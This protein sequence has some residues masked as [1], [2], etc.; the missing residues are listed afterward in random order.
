MGAQ[1]PNRPQ[2][3][4]NLSRA[5]S[6]QQVIGA[7]VEHGAELHEAVELGDVATRLVHRGHRQ[8]DAERRCNVALPE[9]GGFAMEF[10]PLTKRFLI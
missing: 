5:Y 6:H 8:R 3:P 2:P 10:D 7:A 4:Q 9:P 1:T